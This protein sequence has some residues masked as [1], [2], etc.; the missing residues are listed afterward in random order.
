MVDMVGG[1]WV[2]KERQR[3]FS[4]DGKR[5]VVLNAIVGCQK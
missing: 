5:L 2:A 3:V 1:Y 4:M